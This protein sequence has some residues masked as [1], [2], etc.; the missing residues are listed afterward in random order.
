MASIGSIDSTITDLDRSADDPAF[1]ETARGSLGTTQRPDQV[2]AV[3]ED[4]DGAMYENNTPTKF[5]TEK[6]SVYTV[7]NTSVLRKKLDGTDGVGNYKNIFYSTEENYQKLHPYLD[8]R[9]KNVRDVK[10]SGGAMGEYQLEITQSDGKFASIPLAKDPKL[11]AR[12]VDMF[13]SAEGRYI[14][15]LH[16]GH[17]IIEMI[18]PPSKP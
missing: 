4:T 17:K 10:V 8:A 7:T 13:L 1:E 11:S 14:G 9:L 18:D 12:P 2:P 15:K 16:G 5:K 3:A 6:G